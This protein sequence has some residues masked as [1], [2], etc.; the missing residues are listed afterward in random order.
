MKTQD[1]LAQLQ[2]IHT[3]ESIGLWP[4]AWGWWFIIVVFVL[5]IGWT[6]HHLLKINKRNKAKK[7][8]LT[9]LEELDLTT[10]SAALD[11]N[12]ILK[13][14]C[15]AYFA[16]EDIANLTGE[17]WHQWL[18]KANPH[19]QIPLELLSLGYQANIPDYQVQQLHQHTTN[20]IQH[21]S[22]K[23]AGIN[24]V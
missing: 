24:H 4:L 12:S 6:I 11:I 3:P 13:R 7:Q 18:N 2:D 17:N 8:A 15:L 21:L 22:T 19:V 10:P 1:V 20:W 9:L 5:M 23:G 14:V 16:R